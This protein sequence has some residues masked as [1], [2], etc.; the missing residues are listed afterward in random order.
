MIP[1]MFSAE[2][3]YGELKLDPLRTDPRFEK[4]LGQLAPQEGVQEFR[5]SGV[6]GH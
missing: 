5:S 6:L 2:I 3:H 4:L 1:S